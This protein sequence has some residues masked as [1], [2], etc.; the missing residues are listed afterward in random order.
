MHSHSV[1]GQL[2]D[3]GPRM[4]PTNDERLEAALAELTRSSRE[5]YRMHRASDEYRDAIAREM[6]LVDEVRRI[7]EEN[8]EEKTR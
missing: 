4:D 6:L 5:R 3:Y 1:T 2:C 8:R 7:I